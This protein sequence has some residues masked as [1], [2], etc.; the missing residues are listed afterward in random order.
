MIGASPAMSAAP[1]PGDPATG[2]T[3]AD[4]AAVP[5]ARRR[6]ARPPGAAEDGLQ[7]VSRPVRL[8]SVE[9]AVADIATGRP[10]VVVDGANRTR[11]TSS[12]PRAR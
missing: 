3:P 10:V 2:A 6:R 11:A 9:R 12:S 8:D 5:A 1:E 7:P 4:P